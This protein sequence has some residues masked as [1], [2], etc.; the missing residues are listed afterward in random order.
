MRCKMKKKKTKPKVRRT[1]IVRAGALRIP[2]RYNIHCYVFLDTVCRVLVMS[3]SRVLNSPPSSERRAGGVNGFCLDHRRYAH[4]AEYLSHMN[5]YAVTRH[6]EDRTRS[7]LCTVRSFKTQKNAYATETRVNAGS[8]SLASPIVRDTASYRAYTAAGCPSTTGRAG[9]TDRSA[10]WRLPIGKTT[11]RPGSPSLSAHRASSSQRQQRNLSAR[12][13][14][15]PHCYYVLSPIPREPPATRVRFRFPRF[16]TVAY[17]Y[18]CAT[19]LRPAR[20]LYVTRYC[21]AVRAA[22]RRFSFGA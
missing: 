13:S 8:L 3:H 7:P 12:Q 21:S 10:R 9:A 15:T 18:R 4:A 19:P 17:R 14:R 1:R 5:R 2:L 16:N 20:I 22:E 11:R 6:P